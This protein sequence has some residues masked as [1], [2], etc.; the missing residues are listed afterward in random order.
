MLKVFGQFH[1]VTSG[2]WKESCEITHEGHILGFVD[3]QETA[4][5]GL[6]MTRNLQGEVVDGE[7]LDWLLY[8]TCKTDRERQHRG[9]LPA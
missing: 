1:K 9:M 5:A 3:H 6:T 7:R 8:Q 2:E 4:T